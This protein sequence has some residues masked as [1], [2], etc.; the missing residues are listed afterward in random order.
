MCKKKNKKNNNKY[1][2]L[3]LKTSLLL[4]K[5]SLHTKK[6]VRDKNTCDYRYR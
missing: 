6:Q 5:N 2:K 1:A 4:I 3:S